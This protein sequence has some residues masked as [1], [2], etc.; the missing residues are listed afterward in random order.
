MKDREKAELEISL[1][2]KKESF[3]RDLTKVNEELKKKLETYFEEHQIKERAEDIFKWSCEN[4]TFKL[5]SGIYD[6]EISSLDKGITGSAI[7]RFFICR[8]GKYDSN[9]GW[10]EQISGV[11]VKARIDE[12][13]NGI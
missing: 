10:G 11:F 13:E 2:I 8:P 1:V 6:A 5:E 7:K 9:E 12:V 3:D 4:S